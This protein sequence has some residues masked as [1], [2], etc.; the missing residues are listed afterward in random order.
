MW[1]LREFRDLASDSASEVMPPESMMYTLTPAKGAL[2]C[3]TVPTKR[4]AGRCAK[5]V[6]DKKSKHSVESAFIFFI[7][8]VFVM[9]LN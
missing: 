7:T 9:D 4:S 3:F 6:N 5:M 2:F 8:A 1:A